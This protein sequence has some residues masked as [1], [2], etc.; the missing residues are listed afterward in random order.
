MGGISQRRTKDAA[1]GK[2]SLSKDVFV[3]IAFKA[4]FCF[5]ERK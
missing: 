3:E 4:A 2:K 1:S 5:A